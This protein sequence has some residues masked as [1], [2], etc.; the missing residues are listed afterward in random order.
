MSKF[1]VQVGQE[2]FEAQVDDVNAHPVLVTVG[3][4][5]FEVWIQEEE[6]PQVQTMPSAAHA[7]APISPPIQVTPDPLAVA[8]QPRRLVA[9]GKN[10]RAP[11]PGQITKINVAAGDRVE[12]GD[13]LCVLEAMK[14]NNQI[15]A[16]HQ[17]II[18]AVQAVVGAQVN[19][20]DPLIQF[21]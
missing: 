1:R 13:V 18:A 19:Y 7:P 4:Q 9:G 12:R 2:I 17:G 3:D 10:V 5:Q 15:R 16:P 21:E 8:A 14:M 6:G 11:M 20:G